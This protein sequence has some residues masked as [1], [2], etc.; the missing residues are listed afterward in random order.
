MQ[1]RHIDRATYFKELSITSKEYFLPYILQWHTVGQHTNVLEIGCGEGGNLLPFSL[2]GCHIVGVDMALKRIEEAKSF[3][4]EVGVK[5]T[6]I[7]NDIF[8][9]KELEHS[10]DIVICHDVIEHIADKELFLSKLSCFLKCNGIIFMAFPAWQ[11]PFG[12][13]QQICRSSLLSCLPFIHLFPARLYRLVLGALGESNDCINELLSI[14][15]TRVTIEQFENLLIKTDLYIEDRQLWFINPHYKVKF[16]LRPR[17]LHRII[18]VIPYLRN[19]FCSSC[20]Y[21]LAKGNSASK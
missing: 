7:A 19:F 21:I 6:F 12:G 3:F 10:F 8:K 11:M 17:K 20:F 18:S 14:K 9:V 2:I 15:Q 4:S 1:K 5:G 16:G 13:H